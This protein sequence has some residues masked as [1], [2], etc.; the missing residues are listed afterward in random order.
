MTGIVITIDNVIEIRSDKMIQ[1]SVMNDLHTD[2][3][4]YFGYY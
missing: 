2:V 3:L 1:C 4:F